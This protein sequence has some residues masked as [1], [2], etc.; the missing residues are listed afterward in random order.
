M[1]ATAAHSSPAQLPAFGA[2][3]K[4]VEELGNMYQR[5][6][7]RIGRDETYKYVYDAK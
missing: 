1:P 7:R 4:Y 5:S 3:G 2:Q 6:S